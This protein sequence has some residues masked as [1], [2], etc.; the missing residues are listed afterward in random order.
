MDIVVEQIADGILEIRMTQIQTQ[1]IRAVAEMICVVMKKM[2]SVS[3]Q[4]LV[5]L[6]VTHLANARKS[7][8]AV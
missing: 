8:Q 4:I 2:G 7:V 1:I 6:C 5:C 3:I